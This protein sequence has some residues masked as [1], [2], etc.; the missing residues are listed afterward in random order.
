MEDIAYTDMAGPDGVYTLYYMNDE[1]ILMVH[2]DQIVTDR[3]V[4]KSVLEKYYFSKDFFK[5]GDLSDIEDTVLDFNNS[6]SNYYM[7]GTIKTP[8][9]PEDYCLQISGWKFRSCYDK[10][11]CLLTCAAV[12]V[13]KYALEGIGQE[14]KFLFNILYLGTNSSRLN[15]DVNYILESLDEFKDLDFEDYSDADRTRIMNMLEDMRDIKE[16]AQNIKDNF[17][18]SDLLPSPGLQSFCAPVNY[19]DSAINR[20]TY[21]ADLYDDRLHNLIYIDDVVDDLLTNTGERIKLK[22]SLETQNKYT[23][24]LKNIEDKYDTLY[25]KY[26]KIYKVMKDKTLES[27]MSTLKYKKDAIQ[28]YIYKGEYSKSDLTIKQFWVLANDLDDKID[29]YFEKVQKLED[30]RTQIEKKAIIAQWNVEFDNVFLN[31]QLASALDRKNRL[32]S[33]ISSDK[34]TPEE[35]DGVIA[36]YQSVLDDL[37]EIVEVKR[38]HTLDMVLDGVAGLTNSYSN[39]IATA[40]FKVADGGYQTKKNVR[41]YVFPI[42]LLLVDFGIVIAFIGGFMYM[43]TS[44][45]VTLHK[46]AAVLWTFIFIAFFIAVAGGSLAA[47]LII[48]EKT[49]KASFEAFIDD[50][51]SSDTVGIVVDNRYDTLNDKTCLTT[52]KQSFVSM[53]KNVP[54]YTLNIDGCIK[55]DGSRDSLDACM[56]ELEGIPYV[57]LRLDRESDSTKFVRNIHVYADI[58]GSEDYVK[59]CQLGTLIQEV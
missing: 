10:Q 25:S 1:P 5:E 22:K 32:D 9:P 59:R 8:K 58:A 15:D 52:L 38:E 43:I 48:N 12:P 34:I 47:Y 21:L 19:S 13:C 49:V 27:K 44:G 4:L 6:R 20:L 3:D 54:V 31:Q 16:A 33:K 53:G 40:Y 39:L 7:I 18:F 26:I 28:E 51:A 42:T 23:T 29:S 45:K 35:I 14:E 50:I 55:P 57:S 56:E 17:L 2:N 37:N 30:I 41:Q 36:E 24:E 11:S 46:V